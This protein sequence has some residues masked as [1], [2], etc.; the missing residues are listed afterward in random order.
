[1]I[2]AREGAEAFSRVETYSV[3]YFLGF[4]VVAHPMTAFRTI[5]VTIKFMVSWFFFSLYPF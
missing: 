2:V 5:Y 3:N 1:M 4:K